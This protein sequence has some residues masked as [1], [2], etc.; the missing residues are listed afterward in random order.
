MDKKK[1]ERLELIIG[2]IAVAKKQKDG[3]VLSDLEFLADELKEAWNI[4]EKK[5]KVK[6]K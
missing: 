2:A 4:L 1:K 6:K 5:D 3:R